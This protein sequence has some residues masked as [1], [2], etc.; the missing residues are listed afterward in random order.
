M[1]SLQFCVAGAH[2]APPGGGGRVRPLRLHSQR[3]AL[4]LDPSFTAMGAALSTAWARVWE[5]LGFRGRPSVIVL[6]GASRRA[7]VVCGPI[8]RQSRAGLDNAGKTTLLRRLRNRTLTTFAPTEVRTAV[9]S[10]PPHAPHSHREQRANMEEFEVGNVSFRAW[11]LGGHEVQIQTQRVLS[12]AHLL[13]G[14]RVRSQTVRHLW[15]TYAAEANA[16]ACARAMRAQPPERSHPAS[17]V[18]HARMTVVFLVDSADAERFD[19]A[20]VVRGALRARDGQGMTR[21]WH[22]R[23]WKSCSQMR[24]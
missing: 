2:E 5:A 23:S 3:G 21:L 20:R 1:G 7:A 22:C 14:M 19:E 16:S 6:L 24:P 9:D 12:A 4:D 15:D 17:C 18:S 10:C 13:S 11:D 8:H